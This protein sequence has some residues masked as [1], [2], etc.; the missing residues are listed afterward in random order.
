MGID[1]PATIAVLGAGP[2]GLEAALYGRFLGY[3]VHIYERDRVAAN[4]AAWGHVKLFSPF[5]MNRSPLGL[6][7]LAA[8]DANYQVPD[9]D[10]L[11]TGREFV[12]RYLIPLSQTDLLADRIY[13]NTSV[14]AVSREG[15]LK[16]DLTGRESRVET[17]FRI[18]LRD[19][20]GQE[21]NA[22]A[23][24]VIDATGTYG[25]H[26][27]LGAGGIPALGERAA[28]DEIDY[29]LPDILGAR[30][31][32][33]AGKRTLVVG[34]GYSA[35]TTVVALAELATADS[36]TRVVWITR[37]PPHASARPIPLIE[38]D[39]LDERDRLARAANELAV[40]P[41]GPV[42]HLSATT[43]AQITPRS[44]EGVVVTLASAG[45]E[46]IVVDRIIANVGYHPDRELYAELQVHQCY[47]SE[48]PMRLAAALLGE[49][50]GDCLQQPSTGPES[51]TT[52]EPNFYILGAK[53]Y[54]RNSRFLLS[55]G[56][57]QI[58]DL[59]TIIGDRAGLDLYA[60][61]QKLIG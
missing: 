33:F 32:R 44:D 25:N 43:V 53:S 45:N 22:S 61:A 20:T 6:A 55:V 1:S 27:W 12:E 24:V 15:A 41:D 29:S 10:A 19:E 26:G 7:A 40:S 59:F 18:L 50:S 3:D 42:R 57:N 34:A 56:L 52:T 4:V 47:A 51:L 39:R 49:Q 2:I 60:G 37:Q 11:L 5:G 54:G 23:D 48:G 16:T 8:Q 31:E 58:R 9:D 17:P 13:E 35:A 14:V 30:R 38:D 46:H 21:K 28:A 36:A